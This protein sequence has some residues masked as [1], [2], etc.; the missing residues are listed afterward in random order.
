MDVSSKKIHVV[1]IIANYFKKLDS[2]QGINNSKLN[3]WWYTITN[4]LLSL[5]QVEDK[6]Y[7][8]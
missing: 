2:P 6:K 4:D 3:D 1:D 8:T 5:I 7:S